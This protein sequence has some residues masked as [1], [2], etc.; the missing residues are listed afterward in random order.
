MSMIREKRILGGEWAICRNRRHI[1]HLTLPF[2]T[3]PKSRNSF[4][5]WNVLISYCTYFCSV[6]NKT[7]VVLDLELNAWVRNG[8]EK[9]SVRVCEKK[10]KAKSALS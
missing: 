2:C 10:D 8:R 3:S 5:S 7:K 9:G 4:K 6:S 1:K